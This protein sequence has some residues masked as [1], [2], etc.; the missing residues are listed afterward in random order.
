MKKFLG[1]KIFA[2]GQEAGYWIKRGYVLTDYPFD[3]FPAGS[4]VLDVGCGPGEQLEKINVKGCRGI[5]VD[6]SWEAVRKSSEKGLPVVLAKSEELPF[7]DRSFH[8]VLCK[9]VLPYTDEEAVMKSIGSVILPGGTVLLCCH[10]I[11]YYLHYMIFSG[12][13]KTRIYSL[14][15]STGLCG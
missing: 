6:C 5:G 8:G 3:D 4:L 14:W 13:F 7:S 1:N 12:V 11:G 10:G 9:V 2:G 15:F